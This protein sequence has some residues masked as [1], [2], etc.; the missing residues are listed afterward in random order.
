MPV[1]TKPG[2]AKFM[3]IFN[4]N[5]EKGNEDLE[6][7]ISNILVTDDIS[8]TETHCFSIQNKDFE[9][10]G[11]DGWCRALTKADSQEFTGKNMR[12]VDIPKTKEELFKLLFYD[13]FL[14]YIFKLTSKKIKSKAKRCSFL[15]EN[16]QSIIK[17]Y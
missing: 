7:D 2:A 4:P 13:I 6:I 3:Y 15:A 5:E 10:R 16:N 8:E 11:A 9:D 1:S 17:K 12:C 14:E